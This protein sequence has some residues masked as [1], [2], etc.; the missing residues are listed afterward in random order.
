M[1]YSEEPVYYDNDNYEY[2]ETYD[3]SGSRAAKGMFGGAASGALLGGLFGGGRGAGIGAG[4]GAVFGGL[5]GGL[6]GRR[7]EVVRQD[8]YDNYDDQDYVDDYYQD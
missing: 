3:D 5:T 4:V 7:R 2:V 1:Y 8:A 6:S